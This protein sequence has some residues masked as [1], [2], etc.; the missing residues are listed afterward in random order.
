MTCSTI[1]IHQ[2]YRSRPEKASWRLCQLRLILHLK[3]LLISTGLGA[4]KMTE[5]TG[6]HCVDMRKQRKVM[7]T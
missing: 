2:P 5:T 1:G 6:T 4:L 3:L 7:A